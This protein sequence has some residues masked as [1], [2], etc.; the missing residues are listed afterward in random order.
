MNELE[1][2]VVSARQLFQKKLQ[3][4]PLALKRFKDLI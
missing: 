1:P 3:I 2:H 4:A